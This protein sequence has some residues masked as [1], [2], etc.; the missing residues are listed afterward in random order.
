M[1][2]LV[3]G[4]VICTAPSYERDGRAQRAAPMLPMATS[5]DTLARRA[6]R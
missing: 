5:H 4:A 6:R 1:V 2:D 3:A